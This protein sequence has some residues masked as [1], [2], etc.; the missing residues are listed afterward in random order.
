[1]KESF[2]VRHGVVPLNW[3]STSKMS[4]TIVFSVKSVPSCNFSEATLIAN[5]EFVQ[6]WVS[7]LVST[8]LFKLGT[9]LTSC[10][11]F[12]KVSTSWSLSESTDREWYFLAWTLIRLPNRRK[13]L[14]SRADRYDSPREPWHCRSL[15]HPC[16]HKGE[17]LKWTLSALHTLLL[18][19]ETHRDY[20]QTIDKFKSWPQ[21]FSS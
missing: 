19:Y 3:W 4:V 15:A 20:F 12:W 18:G 10:S 17:D 5:D 1:M 8:F 7:V 6:C 13:R 2:Q 9:V 21:L 14:L 16:L 11:S